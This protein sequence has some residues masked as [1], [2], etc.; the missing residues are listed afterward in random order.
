MAPPCIAS[1]R[2]LASS[3]TPAVFRSQLAPQPSRR[4]FGT[5]HDSAIAS[6][7]PSVAG[8]TAPGASSLHAPRCSTR[9]RAQPSSAGPGV[10]PAGQ[11]QARVVLPALL[12]E[13]SAS[14]LLD[15]PSAAATVDQAVAAG[16]TAVVLSEGSAGAAALYDAACKLKDLLRGRAALLLADRADIATAVAAEGVVLGEAGLPTVVA[17]KMLQARIL[18]SSAYTAL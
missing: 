9:C 4:T 3:A 8:T 18:V 13:L 1:Q 10:F 16:A 12:L 5:W 2:K 6:I 7:M 17:R 14:E 11:K 15:S